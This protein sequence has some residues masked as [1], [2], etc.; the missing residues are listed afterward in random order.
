MVD[1]NQYYT[2]YA[3]ATTAQFDAASARKLYLKI[4]KK[5][6]Y[7]MFGDYDTGL[8]V[9]ELGRYSRTLNGFKSEFKGETIK[10]NAFATLTAQSYKKDEIQGDGT[11][12]L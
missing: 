3:D 9:T 8:T 4:E 10:Y 2:L 1:P 7:A 11:S 12:G 6:F 5:Q